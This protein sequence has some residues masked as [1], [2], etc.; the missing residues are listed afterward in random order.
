M[1]SAYSYSVLFLAIG[2]ILGVVISQY[3]SPQPAIA[4]VSTPAY[5]YA[6][7]WGS[8]ETEGD[9]IYLQIPELET[10]DSD[11][12]EIEVY[13]TLTFPIAFE[14]GASGTEMYAV[15]EIA[16]MGW[17][18]VTKY[19]VTDGYEKGHHYWFRRLKQ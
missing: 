3:F 13:K 2:L 5:E 6:Y 12:G 14:G 7:A 11:W 1:K 19:Y 8:L 15:N 18:L 10:T 4:Q 16:D 17:E 9:A